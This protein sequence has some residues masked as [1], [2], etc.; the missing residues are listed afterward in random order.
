MGNITTVNCF[1]TGLMTN[2]IEESFDGYYYFIEINGKKHKLKFL[3]DDYEWLVNSDFIKENKHLLHCLIYNDKWLDN[4]NDLITIENLKELT[5]KSDYPITPNEKLNSL[6]L[7][8]YSLQNQ[9]GEEIEVHSANKLDNLSLELF[10]KSKGEL[11]F[12]AKSLMEKGFIIGKFSNGYEHLIFYKITIDGLSKVIEL[13]TEGENSNLCFVAMSFKEETVPIREAI[14]SAL[15]NTGFRPI[16]IDESHIDSD[17]TINDEIIASLKKCNFCISDF[18]H[19]SNGVYFESGFALGLGKKVI[20]TCSKE[21][22]KKRHF[23]IQPLQHIQYESPEQLKDL[24]AY[25]IEAWIK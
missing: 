8:L 1:I 11:S 18:S 25:K 3:S 13:Q 16:I 7:K 9:D 21:E 19:H 2:D 12:Y 10:F 4:E 22:F 24:L 15:K 17:R 14:K 5:L 23:D 6:L 20:Y